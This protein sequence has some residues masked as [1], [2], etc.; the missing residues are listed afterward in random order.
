MMRGYD[1]AE[2]DQLLRRAEQAAASSDAGLR[3]VV[4]HELQTVRLRERLR[5]YSRVQVD[6]K[7]EQLARELSAGQHIATDKSMP[8]HFKVMM[9][10]YDRAEV[11]QLV[12]RAMQAAASKDP[13]VRAA[14]CHELRTAS[15]RDRLRGYSRV[16]VNERIEQLASELGS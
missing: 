3:A 9:R 8:L 13:A 14:A 6:Q 7:I 16:Q 1:R 4:C 11:D 5:G 15:F 12:G 2:V 10:G